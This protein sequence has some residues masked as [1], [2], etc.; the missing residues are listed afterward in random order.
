MDEASF[1]N[2][3]NPDET[4]F[5][6]SN[7]QFAWIPDSNNSSYANGQIIFD[8]AS[9]SNSGKFVDWQNSTLV[10]PLVLGV[11]VGATAPYGTIENVFAASLKN[12]YHQLINSLSLEITN[13]SVIN[14][15]NFTNLKIKI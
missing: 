1:Q 13:N 4:E 2:S 6:F 11:N 7:R 14:L 3:L 15:T 12:G 8:C 9:L 10:L 5:E